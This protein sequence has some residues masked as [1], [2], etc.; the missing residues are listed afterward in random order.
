VDLALTSSLTGQLAS[1]HLAVKV[2]GLYLEGANFEAGLLTAVKA[3]SPAL[4]E[5]QSFYFAWVP[6]VLFLVV[7][8]LGSD[9]LL[10]PAKCTDFY[11]SCDFFQSTVPSNSS[12]VSVPLYYSTSREHLIS[13]LEIPCHGNTTQWVCAGVALFL[14]SH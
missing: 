5:M 13:S 9:F 7:A 12:Q 4:C 8:Q 1:A 2:S 3:D 11:F 6:K 10:E 14:Q